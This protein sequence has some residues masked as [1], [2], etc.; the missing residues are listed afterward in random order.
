MVNAS[1]GLPSSQQ[2]DDR[3]DGDQHHIAK[4]KANVASK[5]L[6]SGITH[7]QACNCRD[8]CDQQLCRWTELHL[9]CT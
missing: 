7:T 2:V 4:A 5:I 1:A 6:A 8:C 3:S 9:V